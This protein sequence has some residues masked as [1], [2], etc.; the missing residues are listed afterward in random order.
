MA[1]NTQPDNTTGFS[2]EI[3]TD[4]ILIYHIHEISPLT[5]D[6][7]FE[8]ALQHDYEFA[9]QNKHLQRIFWFHHT[10][11]PTAYA[12]SRVNEAS[13]LTPPHLRESVAII[14]PSKVLYQIVSLF[15]KR[16]PNQLPR[17]VTQ[18]FLDEESAVAWLH[19]RDKSLGHPR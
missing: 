7:Y 9:K 1:T 4:G 15:V 11:V 19:E 16:L 18:I 14:V 3:R 13:H 12:F 5:V 2:V 6:A 8:T 10:F 17:N